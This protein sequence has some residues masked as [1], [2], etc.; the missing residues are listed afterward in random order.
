MEYSSTLSSVRQISLSPVLQT[1]SGY[2]VRSLTWRNQNMTI[3]DFLL[4]IQKNSP[5]LPHWWKIVDILS[6]TSHYVKLVGVRGHRLV[7]LRLMD[8]LFSLENKV[9]NLSTL[10]IFFQISVLTNIWKCPPGLPQCR[11]VESEGRV[12]TETCLELQ[13]QAAV[14]R[15]TV[16]KYVQQHNEHFRYI[17]YQKCSHL[18]LH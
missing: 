12:W 16:R 7:H 4:K 15:S 2:G 14:S 8:H 10:Y 9:L 5:P 6:R 11:E 17:S 13:Q 3:A 1:L 18:I